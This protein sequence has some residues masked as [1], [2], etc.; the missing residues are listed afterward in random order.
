M[1]QQSPQSCSNPP[2]QKSTFGFYQIQLQY[3]ERYTKKPL[4]LINENHEVPI[5][6]S[7]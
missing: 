3:Y 5:S 6:F 2:K 4:S 7:T 1:P